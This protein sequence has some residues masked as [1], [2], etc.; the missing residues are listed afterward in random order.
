MAVIKTPA[1]TAARRVVDIDEVEDRAFGFTAATL[2]GGG[3][4]V[5]LFGVI[6]YISE[7]FV[8]TQP[9]LT[10]VKSVGP[11]SGKTTYAVIGWL[12]GWALLAVL[13]RSRD[14]SE[15]ATY[16]ITGILVA[17]GFVLTFPPTWKLLGA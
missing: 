3:F 10:L 4:G 14:V 13:L 12:V 6:T 1:G 5:A 7:A 2:I 15:K 8:S 11:L 16:L 9:G 17:L